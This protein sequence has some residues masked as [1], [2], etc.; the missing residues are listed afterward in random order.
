M[1]VLT[2]NVE[3]NWSDKCEVAFADMKKLISTAP[4][5]QGPKWDLTFHISTD[6]SDTTIGNVHG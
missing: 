4:V 6:A 3:F 1:Y 2:G 5:L